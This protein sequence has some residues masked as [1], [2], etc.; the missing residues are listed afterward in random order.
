MNQLSYEYKRTFLSWGKLSVKWEDKVILTI[1]NTTEH[2]AEKIMVLM[3]DLYSAG[4]RTGYN[5]H[6]NYE[7]DRAKV[8]N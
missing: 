8:L 3:N 4:F 6:G 2:K 5:V 1:K 7:L